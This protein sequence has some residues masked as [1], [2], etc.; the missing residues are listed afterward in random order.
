[1]KKNYKV[2]ASQ[3]SSHDLFFLR[4]IS[5]PLEGLQAVEKLSSALL[6]IS[7]PALRLNVPVEI[8]NWAIVFPRKF[9]DSARE[10]TS[11]LQRVAPP[12]GMSFGQPAV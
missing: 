4:Q 7:F 11:T 1:M 6:F 8:P 2:H 5:M 3:G 10:L 9:G 12:M